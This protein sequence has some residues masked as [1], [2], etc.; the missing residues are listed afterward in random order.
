DEIL[1]SGT[2]DKPM[3]DMLFDADL[4]I[5]DLSTANLNAAFE[6]GIRHALKPRSTIII[7]ENK[8]V[9]PFDVNHVVIRRYEHLGTDIGFS[10][11]MRM[12]KDLRELI[13]AVVKTND[14]DSPVYTFMKLTAPTRQGAPPA[15]AAPAAA[16]GPQA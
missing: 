6:L 8:F 10:E 1:H 4:V 13:E 7:A 14:P 11:A 3:Y 16:G 15:V 9:S 5:A 2:I 12:Q